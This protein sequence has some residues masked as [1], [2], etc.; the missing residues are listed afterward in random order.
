MLARRL[1]P[2]LDIDAGRVVKGVRFADTD[3]VG[4]PVLL[5][6][7]YDREGADE[8]VFY[9]ISASAQGRQTTLETVSAT[10]AVAFIPLTVGGGVDSVEQMRRLLRAGADKV[11]VNSAAVADPDLVARGAD[12]F[13]SQCIVLSIDARRRPDPQGGWEVVTHGGRRPTGLDALEWAVRG[14]AL[15]AGELVLNSIDSDGTRAGYDL[16][17]CRAVS[18]RVGVPVIAS[19]GAGRAD[20]FLEVLTQGAADAALAASVFH[21]GEIGLGELKR[22]LAAH[23]VPVRPPLEG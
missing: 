15:G 6:R 12:K 14:V 16:E 1:I 23:G 5:A 8:L 4:D 7:R 9:D 13:G 18:T 10:A 22:Y 3:P 19:G 20:D 11:S 17:F 2:C 21:R